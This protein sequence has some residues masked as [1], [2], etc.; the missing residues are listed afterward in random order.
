M[1]KNK[2]NGPNEPKVPIITKSQKFF[3]LSST[4]PSHHNPLVFK[5]F[6]LHLFF[7]LHPPTHPSMPPPTHLPM[8]LHS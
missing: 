6:H 4:I 2:Q 7:L 1:I 3:S 5:N 8:P